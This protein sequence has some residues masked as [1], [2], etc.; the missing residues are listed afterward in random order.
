M[1]REK[2]SNVRKLVLLALL[3]AIV[4][5]LQLLSVLFPVYPF[6]LALVLVPIVIGA[7]LIGPLAS[8]WL[9]GVFGIVVLLTSPD[10]PFFMMFN[11]LAT[12][13]VILLRGLLTGLI[14]GMVYKALASMNKTKAVVVAALISPLINTGIFIIG[15]YI[16]FQPIV[17]NVIDFFVAFV[18]LNFLIEM[19]VN[20]VL[21]PTILRL[22]QYKQLATVNS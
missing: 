5:I 7:A 13:L 2:S 4:V 12:V 8:M 18:L 1:T 10:V 22:I 21:C 15:L 19:A 14:A 17:G 16:F 3:T 9:G 11:P 20:I 6:R